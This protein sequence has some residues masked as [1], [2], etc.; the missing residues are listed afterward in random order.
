M[1]VVKSWLSFNDVKLVRDFKV[2]NADSTSTLEDE[3][4]LHRRS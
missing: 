3:R 1:T 2:A 4:V